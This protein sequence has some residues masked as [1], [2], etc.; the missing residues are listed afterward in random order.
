[1]HISFRDM[2]SVSNVVLATPPESSPTLFL[3]THATSE[4]NAARLQVQR[5]LLPELRLNVQL[6]QRRRRH[7]QRQILRLQDRH[8]SQRLGLLLIQLPN[9]RQQRLLT[10]IS[11]FL[12]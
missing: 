3:P 5:F 11:L 8:D 2:S 12:R 10:S 9:Q 6:Q 7:S 1:M 4:A